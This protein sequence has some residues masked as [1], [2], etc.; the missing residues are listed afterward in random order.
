MG[1]DISRVRFDPLRDFAGVVLQQGRLLLDADFN[2]QV[3]MLDR[4][5]RAE[6]CDLTSFGPDPAHQ[7]VAWVP[8]QTPD[9][10]HVEAAGGNLT[11]GR[12][13][14]YVD[15]LLAENHGR[16]P[17]GFDRLLSEPA[18]GA[19]TPYAEQPYWPTPDPLPAGGPH[20]AYLDVWRREV[21]HLEDPGLVDVAVAV[22]TTARTQTVWQ[23]RVLP[24][25]GTATCASDDDEIPG[26]L[27]AIAPSGGRLTTG[28]IPV[29]AEDDPCALPASGGYRGLEN[30]TYR[31]EVHDGGA[32]GTATFKWSRDNGS[33]AFPVVEMVSTTVLRLASLGRDDVLRVS[34]GDWVEIL[35][36]R[37][38]LSRAPGVLRRVTVDDAE[39]TVTFTGALPT[40]LRPASAADAA[41]RRLR[42]RRWDQSGAVKNAAGG[43]LTDL[44]APGATGLIT[45]PAT[46]TTQVVLEHGIVVSFSLASAG[47]RFHSGDHWIVAARTGDT[48]VEILTAAPPL[49]IHHHF[50]RLGTVTFPDA[51]TD[52]R[53]VW[54]PAQEGDGCACTVCVTPESHSSGA[55][56]VQSAIDRV[57]PVG[58][59]VCLEAGVYD[60]GDG[61]D[62]TDA[63]S[64]RLTGVGP[65][66]V[67]VGRGTALNVERSYAVTVDRL[68]VVGGAGGPAAVRLR[69]V[70]SAKLE[71]L[72]VLSLREGAAIAF[73]GVAL[74]LG[75][76]GN[77]LVGSA[78]LEGR[79]LAAALDVRGNV[80]FARG[81]GI[82]LGGEAAYVYDCAV[83]ANDVFAVEGAGVMAT[84]AVVPGGSLSVSANRISASGYGIFVG[85][86]AAV[87]ANTIAHA[88]VDGIVVDAGAFDVAPGHVRVL[89]N[90]VHDLSGTGIALRT[91]V[92]TWLVK[93]NVIGGV[94]TG[95]AVEGRGQ[96]DHVAIEDN[97]V[98]DVAQAQADP[99]SAAGIGVSAVDSAAVLGNTVQRVGTL[100]REG[101][102]RAG[103]VVAGAGTVRV[104]GNIVGEVGPPD[105]FI[106]LSAGVLVLGP[107]RAAVATENTID[108][109][110]PPDQGAWYALL[111]SSAGRQ[112]AHAGLGKAVIGLTDDRGLVL[113]NPW[114]F[115]TPARDDQAT[116]AANTLSGGGRSPTCL[117]SVRGD[118]V[119]DANQCTH[120]GR[121]ETTGIL[122]AGATATATANRVR[123]PKSV[124]V[125]DVPENRVAAVANITANG[126][127]LGSPTGGLPAPWNALNPTVP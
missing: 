122:L 68:A 107:F 37:R 115:V 109:D 22:D 82:D 101:S 31:I 108:G 50:A 55:L 30:Q 100:V 72:A 35:D 79:A 81:N 94:G 24:N 73:E 18:L 57:A 110:A 69:S 95:I 19:D 44:D 104:S 90:R 33:V 62:V 89:A 114:A 21:T 2:E 88:G 103:I 53:R 48:S 92:A 80:V 91:A 23:V 71:D 52:C 61:L 9:A 54:P 1:A 83:A 75:V 106:G 112:F 41:A 51:E 36:D 11:I 34:T 119:S 45:I 58:G 29:D 116:V 93:Q 40:D 64:L 98:S 96:A 14:M 78:G 16:P 46:A 113:S 28:T 77:V 32:P 39:R 124:L 59:T 126:T 123:G 74:Q 6:A 4:R 102:V 49:G 65:A 20:L 42:V 66:S 38:E 8:R 63:R 3:A 5:L 60:V 76:R 43:T 17:A 67:L 120:D 15:G 10:F 118:A 127:R 97:E 13:R 117:V 121:G 25:I 85:T 84:G 26:W 86:D 70:V 99:G 111:I 56:T 105:D 47:T 87:D 12:G 7:G 27:D 125:L